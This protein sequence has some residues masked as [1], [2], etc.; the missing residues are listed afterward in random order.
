MMDPMM[1]EFATGGEPSHFY[2]TN[3]T[4]IKVVIMNLKLEAMFWD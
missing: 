1:K 3:L 4:N 2:S